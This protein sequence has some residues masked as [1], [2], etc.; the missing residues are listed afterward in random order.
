MSPFATWSLN[1]G[2]SISLRILSGLMDLIFSILFSGRQL[3]S[4]PELMSASKDRLLKYICANSNFPFI[5]KVMADKMR[6]HCSSVVGSVIAITLSCWFVFSESASFSS[7]GDFGDWTFWLSFVLPWWLFGWAMR[8]SSHVRARLMRRVRGVV[9][10]GSSSGWS[11]ALQRKSNVFH[12]WQHQTN[13]SVF[14]T[15]QLS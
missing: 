3:T 13:T 9:G 14:F 7:S 11:P 6:T 8:S 2:G 10:D 12:P 5:F 15:V 1:V 4:A